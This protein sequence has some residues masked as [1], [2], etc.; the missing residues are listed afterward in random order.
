[1]TS[2]SSPIWEWV[3]TSD[4]SKDFK[5][6]DRKERWIADKHLNAMLCDPNPLASR[7]YKVCNECVPESHLFGINDDGG[8]NKRLGLLIHFNW[9]RKTL[10]NGSESRTDIY[11]KQS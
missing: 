4:F 7:E 2:S 11:Y 10:F 6:L 9:E 5:Q 3:S 8:G 1:M